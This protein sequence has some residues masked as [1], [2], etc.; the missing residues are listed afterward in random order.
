MVST[1]LLGHDNI[2]RVALTADNVPAS[3]RDVYVRI[4][5][6]FEPELSQQ[7]T[8]GIDPEYA[9][10]FPTDEEGESTGTGNRLLSVSQPEAAE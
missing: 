5:H 8:A 7:I 4:H 6:T 9:F 3:E 1:H 2:V 10:I